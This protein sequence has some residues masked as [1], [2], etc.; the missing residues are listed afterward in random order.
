MSTQAEIREFFTEMS[1]DL[2]GDDDYIRQTIQPFVRKYARLRA[3]AMEA[4]TAFIST[5]KLS[6]N[7]DRWPLK[8]QALESTEFY[9]AMFKE[10]FSKVKAE[11]L[12]N[13][14][15]ALFKYMEIVNCRKTNGASKVAALKEA[16]LI[17]GVTVIDEDGKVKA[18]ASLNEFYQSVKSEN[19]ATAA[20]E[21]EI[22]AGPESDQRAAGP[23]H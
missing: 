8:K 19:A 18:G 10:E 21:A 3:H 2:F 9:A 7:D 11:D 13:P 5:F 15:S 17:A 23:L 6:I 4:G 12:L 1:I 14:K 20:A 16:A 22:T